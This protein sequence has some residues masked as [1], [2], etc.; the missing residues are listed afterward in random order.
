MVLLINKGRYDD[1]KRK[2]CSKIQLLAMESLPN[3]DHVNVFGAITVIVCV[4]YW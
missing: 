4:I 2:G 3:P 1:T